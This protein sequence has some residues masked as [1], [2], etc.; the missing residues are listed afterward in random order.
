MAGAT[1]TPLSSRHRGYLRLL[2][3]CLLVMVG[4][5]LPRP[6]NQLTAL[7]YTAM[8]LVMLRSFNRP[9]LRHNR[10]FLLLG[11]ATLSCAVFWYLTPVGLHSTGVPVLLLWSLFSLWSATRLI[12]SLAEERRVNG[13]VLR[14]ALA[15]YL[16]LGLTAGL[17]CSA[18]ETIGP[19]NFSNINLGRSAIE[20]QQPVWGLNFVKLNY[21]AF[22]TLTT[23][24]YGDVIP[25]TPLAQM[26][27]MAIAVAGTVYQAVVMGLLI[28]RFTQSRHP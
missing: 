13:A 12:R 20:I 26:L 14:G 6:F 17:I 19:G 16:M 4:F 8:G 27:T 22:V 2:S 1:G 5:T 11:G 25:Q 15:G 7:G 23:T 9:G 18:L 21:F 24:G 28:S 3:T 10:L